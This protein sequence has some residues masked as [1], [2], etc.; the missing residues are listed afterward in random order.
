MK[1]K[2]KDYFL[3]YPRVKMK[4]DVLYKA[5]HNIGQ[6]KLLANRWYKIKKRRVEI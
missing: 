4:K 6:K 1:D 2:Y 3:R 5:V